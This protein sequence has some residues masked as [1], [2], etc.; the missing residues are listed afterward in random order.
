[1]E[2]LNEEDVLVSSLLGS[3]GSLGGGVIKALQPAAQKQSTAR[4]QEGELVGAALPPYG[5]RWGVPNSAIMSGVAR[6]SSSPSKSLCTPYFGKLTQDQR[7]I[8]ELWETRVALQFC[9]PNRQESP[10]IIRSEHQ[11]FVGQPVRCAHDVMKHPAARCKQRIS[12]GG[13]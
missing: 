6:V 12:H 4:G 7:A 2:E 10:Q 9:T 3:V 13:Q 11:V 8:V 1:M 5:Q